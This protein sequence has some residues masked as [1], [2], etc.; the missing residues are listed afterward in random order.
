MQTQGDLTSINNDLSGAT[1]ASVL[2]STGSYL[3][4]SV[5]IQG[6]MGFT[7]YGIYAE[8][9]AILL[10]GVEFINT[11]WEILGHG[12]IVS[13]DRLLQMDSV[14]FHG[15]GPFNSGGGQIGL[16]TDYI[17]F[18]VGVSNNVTM[19]GCTPDSL[20]SPAGP[21]FKFAA[22]S[23]SNFDGIPLQLLLAA[24][25]AGVRI[26]DAGNVSDVRACRRR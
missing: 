22:L 13:A 6:H 24:R 26:F 9:G 7:P 8:A 2:M 11:S 20:A 3:A 16:R 5:F 12:A 19:N 23:N 17:V 10:G 1:F 4:G 14:H 15:C 25:T 18:D 21:P